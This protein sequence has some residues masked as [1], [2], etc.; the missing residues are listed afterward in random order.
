MLLGCHG[1]AGARGAGGEHTCRIEPQVLRAKS[2]VRTRHTTHEVLEAPAHGS[3]P[4]HSI[5]KTE[6][7][8]ETATLVDVQGFAVRRALIEV[9]KHRLTDAMGKLAPGP[10]DGVTAEITGD[11]DLISV[12]PQGA[13]LDEASKAR[14]ADFHRDYGQSNPFLAVGALAPSIGARSSEFEAALAQWM[15]RTGAEVSGHAPVVSAMLTRCEP[16]A[17]T[18]RIQFRITGRDRGWDLDG[19]LDGAMVIAR[20]DG[21][22]TSV[23]LRAVFTGTA[24]DAKEKLKGSSEQNVVMTYE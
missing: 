13:P 18:F 8:E 10:L 17:A 24:P 4:A 20:H 3:E 23:S 7:R 9:T 1:G 12:H 22:P 16:E 6:E 5:D 2:I 21:R 15:R 19:H 11:G 14:L